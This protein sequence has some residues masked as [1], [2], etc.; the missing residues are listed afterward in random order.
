[1][2]WGINLDGETA[3]V[4][5]GTRNIGLAIA[6][7][8]LHHGAKVCIVG[9][10][11]RDALTQALARLGGESK[12]ISGL[13]ASVDDERQVEHIFDHTEERLGPAT[14]LVNGAASRPHQAFTEITKSQWQSVIDVILTGAFLTAQQLFRRLPEGRRGAIVNLGGLSAHVPKVERPHVIAAKAGLVG[15]TRALAEEGAARIRVNCIVPGTIQTE[16]K[17]GQSNPIADEPKK[18]RPLGTSEDVARIVL[19]FTDP[20]DYYV[21]GQTVH[22][23]GGR[24]MP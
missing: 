12:R 10:A 20:R 16:R 4:T 21:T 19:P 8:L 13:L 6:E 5:G 3:I 9:G 22:V 24:Y 11:D 1:M 14:I 18:G 17:P 23:S 2:T 15:L 7:G